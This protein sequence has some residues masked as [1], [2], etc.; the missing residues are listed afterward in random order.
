VRQAMGSFALLL[1][2]DLGFFFARR[3]GCFCQ[4]LAFHGSVGRSGGS[5]VKRVFLLVANIEYL[6][7]PSLHPHDRLPLHH[8][9]LHASYYSIRRTPSP[10]PSLYVLSTLSGHNSVSFHPIDLGFE[11]ADYPPHPLRSTLQ[12]PEPVS[13]FTP[14]PAPSRC[15]PFLPC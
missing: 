8:C 4:A 10:A 9:Q 12:T 3:S 15:L 5:N 6:Q 1:F 7:S 2:R 14:S 11:A 13:R